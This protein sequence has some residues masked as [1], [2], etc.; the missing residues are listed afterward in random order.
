[1][2][3]DYARFDFGNSYYR[4]VPVLQLIGEKLPVSISLGLWTTLFHLFDFHTTWHCQG[5]PTWHGI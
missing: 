2:M 5:T 4:D 3:G 1:M